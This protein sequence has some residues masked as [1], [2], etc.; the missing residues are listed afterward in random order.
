MKYGV[1]NKELAQQQVEN[2]FKHSGEIGLKYVDYKVGKEKELLEE[3]LDSILIELFNKKMK[4]LE[5]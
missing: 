4:N 1:V 5:G 3:K 2:A